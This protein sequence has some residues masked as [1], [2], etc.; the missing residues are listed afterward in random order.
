MIKKGLFPSPED[1]VLCKVC[2]AHAKLRHTARAYRKTYSH[3]TR[4][5]FASKNKT[6]RGRHGCELY[7]EA[8]VR[9]K[10]SGDTRTDFVRCAAAAGVDDGA[11]GVHADF[12]LEVW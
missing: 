11:S 1:P 6:K 9:S 3:E 12:L 4:N 5:K 2:L 8:E 10:H 7:A